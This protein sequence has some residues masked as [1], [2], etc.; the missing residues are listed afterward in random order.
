MQ[1]FTNTVFANFLEGVDEVVGAGLLISPFK[2][3]ILPISNFVLG[4]LVSSS[5]EDKRNK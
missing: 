4:R 1:K 5:I 2:P 3:S